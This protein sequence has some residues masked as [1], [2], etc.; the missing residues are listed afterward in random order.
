M[1]SSKLDNL[2]MLLLIK[3]LEEIKSFVIPEIWNENTIILRQGA[4]KSSNRVK[5]ISYFNC[6]VKHLI[7]LKHASAHMN[8]S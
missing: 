3:M 6:Q 5:A 2:S 8:P 7:F 4:N 1:A